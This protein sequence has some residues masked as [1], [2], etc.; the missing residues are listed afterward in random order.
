MNLT[1]NLRKL[2]GGLLDDIGKHLNRLGVT[3]NM[4]TLTGLLMNCLAAFFITQD[5]LL[6]AGIIVLV[7]GPLDA[8]DGAM[9]RLRG[10]IQPFGAFLD[11]V[12]DR[13]SEMVIFFGLFIQYMGQANQLVCLLTFLAAAGSFLVSYTRA[14]SESL[15]YECRAG[16][17]TRVE[18][19]LVMA[20]SL[21]ANQIL[22]GLL[23]IAVGANLTA[24][25]R[26]IV[27]KKQMEKNN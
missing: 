11:S 5:Q 27:V 25:Q 17:M 14:R 6:T 4:V 10:D 23:I 16:I 13:Y 8:I 24:L 22:I 21:I 3:P 15:G 2:F 18:R 1:D 12:V 20:I 7:T 26:I 19:F 9:A